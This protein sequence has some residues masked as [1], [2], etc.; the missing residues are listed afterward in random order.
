MLIAPQH[1]MGR[2]SEW[3]LWT[4]SGLCFSDICSRLES[5]KHDVP[6]KSSG[7]NTALYALIRLNW[8]SCRIEEGPWCS[9][10]SRSQTSEYRKAENAPSAYILQT[11][12]M[13]PC[14]LLPILI[15]QIQTP[16]P[17][18]I[19]DSDAMMTSE[20][21]LSSIAALAASA[22]SSSSSISTS[23]FRVVPLK[24]DNV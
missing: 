13:Y 24:P 1:I 10:T 4:A 14:D 23:N 19:L 9:T 21:T 2:N 6:L 3:R 18:R 17:A 7:S 16:P 11:L 12:L 15:L 5:R 20:T 22:S 8:S